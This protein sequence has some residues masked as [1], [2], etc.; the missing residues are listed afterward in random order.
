MDDGLHVYLLVINDG[1]TNVLKNIFN[2]ERFSMELLSNT[3]TPYIRVTLE[4]T[5]LLLN[6]PISSNDWYLNTENL[7]RNIFHHIIAICIPNGN[8]VY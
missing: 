1:F 8:F 3:Q 6:S 5:K 2:C 7:H 4:V